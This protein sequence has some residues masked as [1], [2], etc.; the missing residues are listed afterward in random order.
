MNQK[1]V[2]PTYQLQYSI[3]PAMLVVWAAEEASQLKLCSEDVKNQ[4]NPQ[5]QVLLNWK[6]S[7]VWEETYHKK[8]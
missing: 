7:C 1:S 4:T 8:R 6:L 3:H 5:S 2:L